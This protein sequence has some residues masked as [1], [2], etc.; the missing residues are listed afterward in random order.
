MSRL[1][2]RWRRPSPWCR[3]ATRLG[4]ARPSNG[5]GAG[6]ASRGLWWTRT[7]SNITVNSFSPAA[8]T[9]RL[10]SS[11][12]QLPACGVPRRPRFAV[13]TSLSTVKTSFPRPRS[14]GHRA[15]ATVW[16]GPSRERIDGRS[17]FKE[18][19]RA[20][21]PSRSK[22]PGYPPGLVVCDC[23]VRRRRSCKFA[24]LAAINCPVFSLKWLKLMKGTGRTLL[25]LALAGCASAPSFFGGSQQE[26][27]TIRFPA[28][29]MNRSLFLSNSN[30]C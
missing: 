19:R 18:S 13:G 15:A 3:P 22:R 25:C 9:D 26:A 2:A 10:G 8:T 14:R 27:E 30:F 23:A 11:D 29:P 6:A 17:G 21:V 16:I 1:R 4:A 24:G 5:R 7:P 12:I 20:M 28:T